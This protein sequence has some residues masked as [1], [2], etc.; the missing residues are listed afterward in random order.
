MEQAEGVENHQEADVQ[1]EETALQR[2][3]GNQEY[4][5][6]WNKIVRMFSLLQNRAD[7]VERTE[8]NL[9]VLSKC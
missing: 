2:V 4:A 8:Q 3:M 1:Q 9:S 5:T 6:D 7:A